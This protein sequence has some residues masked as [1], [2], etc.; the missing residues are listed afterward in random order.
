LF[1]NGALKKAV[2]FPDLFDVVG[3]T[4]EVSDI[5]FNGTDTLTLTGGAST[6]GIAQND[7]LVLKKSDNTTV[8]VNVDNVTTTTLDISD[9]GA[10]DLPTSAGSVTLQ[11][12]TS[13]DTNF[14]L[15]DLRNRSAIGVGKA[16]VHTST[17]TLGQQGGF[18]ELSQGGNEL[19]DDS[20][21]A[22]TFSGTAIDSIQDPFLATN[23][24][25]RAK[26]GVKALVF[27]GHNHDDLY[28]RIQ[29]GSTILT[30]SVAGPTAFGLGFDRVAG[31]TFPC[32][33]ITGNPVN[34]PQIYHTQGAVVGAAN[35]YLIGIGINDSAETSTDSFIVYADK[36]TNAPSPYSDGRELLHVGTDGKHY[37]RSDGDESGV[38][39][40]TPTEVGLEILGNLRTVTGQSYSTLQSQSSSGSITLDFDDGNVHQITLG[41]SI[42]LAN[43]SNIKSGAA[44]TIILKQDS[45]GGRASSHR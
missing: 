34:G 13:T 23:F 43:P 5:H 45:T 18:E 1:C 17:R 25:I 6:R 21:G 32:I 7:K 42:S 19:G 30:P 24:I 16:D 2:D 11:S 22:F 26:P 33:S 20:Q 31:V 39:T 40:Y 41:G 14:F 3:H 29:G 15:P 36:D 27:T 10:G 37:F 35:D 12:D 38:E 28:P 9:A 44:Y 8:V 4:Y